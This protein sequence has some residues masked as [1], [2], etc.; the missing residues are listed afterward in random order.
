[1]MSTS[2][3]SVLKIAT[4]SGSRRLSVMLRLFRCRFWK[5]KPWRLPPMP[6]PERPPGISILMAC[7]PQSTSWRTHVGPARARVRS[8]TLKR[9]SGRAAFSAMALLLPAKCDRGHHSATLHPRQRAGRVDPGRGAVLDGTRA[10]GQYRPGPARVRARAAAPAG[11]PRH[12]GGGRVH[13]GMFVEEKRHG[14]SQAGAFQDIFGLA[15]RAEAWGIDC[16]WL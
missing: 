4:P 16:L 3:A 6:S 12:R 5:S 2:R 9:A 11:H 15:D 14:V 1:M 8:R 7:A 13:F 10:R